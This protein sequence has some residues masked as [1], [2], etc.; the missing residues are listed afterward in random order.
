MPSDQ[1]N[2][3][4]TLCGIDGCRL[5]ENHTGRHNRFPSKAWSEMN[6]KDKAK[7]G[8]AGFATPRGGKK[9]AYQNHVVRSNKVII[10]YE[11][12]N[13]CDVS[14]YRDG[15]VV[16][17]LPDQYFV[18]RDK[19]KPEFERSD[20]AIRVGENAFVLYRTHESFERFPPPSGWVV[21]GLE[22]DGEPAESRGEGIADVGH[23]VLRLP[24]IG[25][26]G[27]RCDGPPQGIFAP[28]YADADANFLCRCVLAWLTVHTVDSPYTTSQFS[29]L[30]SILD[31]EGILDEG[32]W[33]FQGII[34]HGLT[35]CPLCSRFIRYSHLHDMLT[36]DDEQA[37]ENAA[38]QVEG[39]TRSTIVNLFHMYPLRYGEIDHEPSKV[40][41]G[42]AV[43]NTKL[44]Q[45]R[46]FPL[47]ELIDTGEKIGLIRPEGIE[48][49][50]W[51]S[52]DWEMIRAPGGSVWIRLCS[53]DADTI[54]D[55]P[56]VAGE[57]IAE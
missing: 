6:A 37:L 47:Q 46:C 44:G 2:T 12:F 41:W 15:W 27:E 22:K 28:E 50:G 29:L 38:V 1:P 26:R 5:R 17:L 30:K 45:R 11:R 34:R 3:I 21:R 43:C 54:D 10:P 25:V 8:K 20:T 55:D 51:I 18:S 33:E 24:R 53:D 49:F 40:A 36:L 32:V 14:P 52:K 56:E 48:T 19:P 42:H 4:V 7:L 9:G 35:S 13:G 23:Y 31:S 57:D 16:R 39:A